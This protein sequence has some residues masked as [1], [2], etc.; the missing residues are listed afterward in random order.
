MEGDGFD[1]APGQD[2][3]YDLTFTAPETGDYLVTVRNQPAGKV[4]A[5]S[6]MLRLAIR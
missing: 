4:K 1:F 3:N 2:A 6:F 5:A